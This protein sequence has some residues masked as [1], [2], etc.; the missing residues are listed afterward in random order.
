MRV[1]DQFSKVIIGKT[2]KV[3]GKKINKVFVALKKPIEVVGNF[4]K[5]NEAFKIRLIA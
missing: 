5:V 1:I 2:M 3:I 4:S